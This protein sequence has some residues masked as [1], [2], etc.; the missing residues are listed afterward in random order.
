M[1][2]ATHNACILVEWGII[3]L[4]TLGVCLGL[5]LRQGK[6]FRERGAETIASTCQRGYRGGRWASRVRRRRGN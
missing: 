3:G 4:A 2:A 1:G 5:I 6:A